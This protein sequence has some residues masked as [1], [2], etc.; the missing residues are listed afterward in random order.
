MDPTTDGPAPSDG[1]QVDAGPASAPTTDAAPAAQTDG[2]PDGPTNGGTT[3]KADTATEDLFYDPAL[4]KGKPELEAA[5]KQMQ[6]SYTK[7]M[8]ALAADRRKIEAFDQ[9]SKD[10]LT[11]IQQM[12]SRMGYRLTRA[13]AAQQMAEQNQAAAKDWEPQTWDDVLG[14][15]KQMAKEEIM[16]EL[17]PVFGE[18]QGMRK[19]TIE[20]QL[21]ELDPTW[22]QYEDR[23]MQNLR[24]HPT[25]AS[26]PATLYRLSVPPDVL[27]SRATQA[28]L[29]KLQ[30]KADSG[31]VSGTSTTRAAP[32][33][34]GKA[35]SFSEAVEFAKKQLASQ[36]NRSH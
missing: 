4:I 23:M 36:G 3:A 35:M 7:R 24:S 27:E 14:R 33:D 11:Q 34:P 31:R 5:H 10:P 18:L 15:A 1:G 6:A 22:H 26:D 2:Q 8:Q 19:N 25:L 12:A 21:S 13:E 16:A 17:Q 28:A 9:F 20:K 32:P 29:R 30:A